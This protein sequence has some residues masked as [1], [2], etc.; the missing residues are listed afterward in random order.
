MFTKS[1]LPGDWV[2]LKTDC[3]LPMAG[4]W[5]DVIKVEEGIWWGHPI[6]SRGNATGGVQMHAICSITQRIGD[7][8]ILCPDC[9][10]HHPL[11]YNRL[12]S[13][14]HLPHGCYGALMNHTSNQ[15]TCDGCK[16]Y[17]A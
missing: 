13:T 17:H 15:P 8:P 2:E 4:K 6:D 16:Y 7:R 12:L 14:C 11:L 3:S 5:F 10:Q 1:I 9:G